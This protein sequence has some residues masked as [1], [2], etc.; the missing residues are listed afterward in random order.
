MTYPRKSR[1][2][3]QNINLCHVVNCFTIHGMISRAF[4]SGVQ[5]RFAIASWPP[6][7]TKISIYH[8]HELY[9]TIKKRGK[10][11]YSVCLG[12]IFSDM[13]PAKWEVF[14]KIRAD[15]KLSNLPG[16]L[17]FLY[18]YLFFLIY[19]SIRNMPDPRAV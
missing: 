16:S 5:T 2:G 14:L 1:Q 19:V 9:K 17:S 11:L 6:G 4:Y 13:S 12:E 15:S 10:D 18:F 3:K 8:A 7:R